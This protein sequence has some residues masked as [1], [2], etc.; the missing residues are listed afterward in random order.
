MHALTNLYPSRRIDTKIRKHHDELVRSIRYFDIL[1]HDL[2]KNDATCPPLP[3]LYGY[4]R[5]WISDMKCF[6]MTKLLLTGSNI[7]DVLKEFLGWVIAKYD[8]YR[9]VPLDILN[10]LE[11]LKRKWQKGDWDLGD[12]LRGIHVDLHGG[13]SLD[14]SWRFYKPD[15]RQFGKNGL[16]VGESWPHQIA[17]MRDGGH[18]A[19]EAGIS[20]VQGEG[21]T[22]LILS[23]PEQREDYADIDEGNRIRYMSTSSRTT[24]PTRCTELLIASCEWYV[25]CQKLELEARDEKEEKKTK[26]RKLQGRPVRL[27]RSWRLSEK[28]KWRPRSGFR[29]DGLYDVVDCELIDP[30]H[31]LFRFTLER[32]E[33]QGEIR[34]DQPDNQT[35]LLYYQAAGVQK[36]AKRKNCHS[37]DGGPGGGGL[38][39]SRVTGQRAET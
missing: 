26:P 39:R 17:I 22:S 18:G 33:G 5:K 16:I 24:R 11:W 1:S 4:M 13:R 10:D 29:Y 21:A 30:A 25:L 23:N 3:L 36:A 2:R 35:C 15:W 27:F 32:Q 34:I 31:A 37:V 8:N 28:N 7:L 20:G 38:K 9:R 12:C 19:P 6:S 14:K